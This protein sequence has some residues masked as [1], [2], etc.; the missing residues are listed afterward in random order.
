MNEIDLLFVL[1]QYLLVSL[2]MQVSLEH[3]FGTLRLASFHS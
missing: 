1:Y 3:F 2:G